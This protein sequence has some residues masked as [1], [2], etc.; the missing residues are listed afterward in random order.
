LAK[1]HSILAGDLDQQSGNILRRKIHR[2][3][4]TRCM[5]NPVLSLKAELNSAQF[6]GP[7]SGRLI[8]IH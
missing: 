8:R 2:V 6:K 7:Y 1:R 4:R 5:L 3:K